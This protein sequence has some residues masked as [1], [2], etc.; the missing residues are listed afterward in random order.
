MTV[1][2]IVSESTSGTVLTVNT[3][4]SGTLALNGNNS[5]SGGT[6]INGGTVQVNNSSSLG[7]GLVTLSGT[8]GNPVTLEATATATP[9]NNFAISGTFNT[10]QVDLG[11]IYTIGG[12]VSDGASAG[13]LSVVGAGTLTL[14]GA[15]T[16]SGGT[17][18][19]MSG[20]TLAIGSSSI[21]SGGVILSGPIGTGA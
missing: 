6:I 15:N 19:N 11:A 5:Y 3:S 10:V 8:S 18:Y 20:G 21:V 17:T 9:T 14:T 1:S 2:G 16:Y 13:L 12:T 7:T 4:G